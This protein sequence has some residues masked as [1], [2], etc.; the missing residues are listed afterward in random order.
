MT[1]GTAAGEE[2]EGAVFR[3]S[4]KTTEWY[5]VLLDNQANVSIIHP[6]LLTRIRRS[7]APTRVTG[8]SPEAVVLRL[9]GNLTSFFR[10]LVSHDSPANVLCMADVEDLYKVTYISGV[11]YT[12]HMT[13]RDLVFHRRNKM[14]VANMQD[15]E[16]YPDATVTT[17]TA[18]TGATR[19]PTRCQT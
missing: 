6:R 19:T 1:I 8:I 17:Q 14:Y 15:W 4:A 12:V 9:E 10:A 18:T 3:T 5:E 2:L 7:Q 13:K 11:S 16:T